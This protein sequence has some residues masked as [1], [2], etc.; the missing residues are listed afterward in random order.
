MRRNEAVCRQN[1]IRCL[2]GR[3]VQDLVRCSSVSVD[4][5]PKCPSLGPRGRNSDQ[6]CVRAD[7]TYALGTWSGRFFVIGDFKHH[8]NLLLSASLH[9]AISVFTSRVYSDYRVYLRS[10]R[11][12]SA[13]RDGAVRLLRGVAVRAGQKYEVVQ[14]LRNGVMQTYTFHKVSKYITVVTAAIA[15]SSIIK[16]PT[17]STTATSEKKY[18]VPT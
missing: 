17:P 7:P 13:G 3:T 2:H 10:G 8:S 1:F 16:T 14:A 9:S 4:G 11:G 18:L 15:A 6:S 5:P 12:P